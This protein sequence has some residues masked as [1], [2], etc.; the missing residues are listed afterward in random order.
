MIADAVLSG[1]SGKKLPKQLRLPV[2]FVS[3]K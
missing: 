2:D 1:L 3:A